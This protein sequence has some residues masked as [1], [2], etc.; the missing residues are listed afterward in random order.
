MDTTNTAGRRVT[1]ADVARM[2]GVSKQTASRVVNGSAQV[3]DE[4][5]ARVLQCIEV[6]GFRPSTLAR[7]LTAGR[8]LTLG[9]V[10]NTAVGHLMCGDAYVGMVRQADGMGYALLNKEMSDF[11]RASVDAMLGQMLERQVDGIILAGPEIGNSHD[12]LDDYPLDDLPMPLVAINARPRAGVDVVGFDNFLAGQNATRHLLSLQRRRIGHLSG[13][14]NRWVAQRRIEGWQAALDEAGLPE[15]KAYCVEGSWEAESGGPGLQRLLELCPDLD[16]VFVSSDRMAL[17]VLME[18]QRLGI[19]VP[20]TLAVMGIDNDPQSAFFTPP[21][22]TMTQDT[23]RMAEVALRQLVR[24]ICDRHGEPYPA[25]CAQEE[26]SMLTHR[27]I[28]RQ[29]TLGDVAN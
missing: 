23:P 24:R 2:A 13:P 11:S 20:G 19:D 15:C 12:W 16:A 9:V 27:L 7:Q 4:T 10:N 8:S 28:V 14:N 5:R 1:L 3:T 26:S 22:T 17:G 21:L 25:G 29:S 18:A 6:L